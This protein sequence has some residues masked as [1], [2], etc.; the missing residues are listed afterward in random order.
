MFKEKVDQRRADAVAKAIAGVGGQMESFHFAFGSDD[1]Y[2][3]ANLP[4]NESAIAMAATVCATGA[5]SAYETVVLFTP[6]QIDRAVGKSIDYRA[7]GT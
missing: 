1:V 5:L 2:V 3:I 6:E 4:D 7:P